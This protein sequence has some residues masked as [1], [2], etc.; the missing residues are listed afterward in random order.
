M[1]VDTEDPAT[2]AEGPGW[3][4]DVRAA[5]S[6]DVLDAI[7]RFS[8]GH[9]SNVGHLLGLLT[10]LPSPV[11]VP[12]LLE[13]L[14]EIDPLRLRLQV[15]GHQFDVFREGVPRELIEQ[16]ARG[17][18][19]A[20]RELLGL[21]PADRAEAARHALSLDPEEARRLALQICRGWHEH[22][23]GPQERPVG[24]LLRREAAEKRALAGRMPV[25]ALVELATNGVALSR[26]PRIERVVLVPAVVHR[27]WVVMGEHYGSMLFF[28]GITEG[29]ARSEDQPP[30]ELIRLT[31]ALGDETRL[32]LLRR[33]RDG[34]PVGLQELAD[35]VG[36]A[37]S[38]VHAHMLVL[39][40]AGLVRAGATDKRYSLRREGAERVRA[41]LGDW[42]G[43]EGG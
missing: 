40:T 11:D 33:L 22:V 19:D 29:P 13:L 37:K 42:L 32:R 8:G 20:E 39:R 3:F 24:R 38:T 26:D 9:E 27:P 17:D 21:W 41:L 30:E 12:A 4:D 10:E 16:A 31:K 6:A 18:R 28:Y 35:H 1:L 34:H 15:L 2:Y 14:E 5:L 36:L 7:E 25:A 23:L 43:E